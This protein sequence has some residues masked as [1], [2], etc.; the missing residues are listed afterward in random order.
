MGSEIETDR[1][2]LKQNCNG[3]SPLDNLSSVVNESIPSV[4]EVRKKSN[5]NTS[6]TTRL[7]AI[8]TTS[9]ESNTIKV[10]H[11]DTD[12]D[13]IV[14]THEPLT[15]LESSDVV[16][17]SSKTNSSKTAKGI[18]SMRPRLKRLDSEVLEKFQTV[19][20][21][22]ETLRK[23]SKSEPDT[24]NTTSEVSKNTVSLN[25]S[26]VG[27]TSD[28]EVHMNLLQ[29]KKKHQKGES[30]DS[31][32]V[33]TVSLDSDESMQEDTNSKPE[34]KDQ[35]EEENEGESEDNSSESTDEEVEEIMSPESDSDSDFDLK[36]EPNVRR[37]RRIKEDKKA[38]EKKKNKKN[39]KGSKSKERKSKRKR[40]VDNLNVSDEI[41]DED[42]NNDDDSVNPAKQKAS[43]KK[44]RRVV[45]DDDESNTEETTVELSSTTNTETAKEDVKDSKQVEKNK[46]KGEDD[47]DDEDGSPGKSKRKNIRQILSTKD[48]E[49]DTRK[50]NLEER[51]R[52]KRIG[53][54]SKDG[55]TDFYTREKD[56]R[57]VYTRICFEK[58]GED[59]L[60]C[61]H[62]DLANN[63]KPHQVEGVQFLWDCTVE[64]SS[65][66]KETKGSG[67]ILAHCMG[68]GKTLQ[69]ISFIHTMLT[70]EVLPF[71]TALIIVPANT[72]LNWVNEFE[73]WTPDEEELDVYEISQH[74]DDKTRAS[75]LKNWHDKGG[76]MIIGYNMFRIFVN[77][78]RK[79]AKR[80]L[81][82]VKEALL[83]P[84]PD[85]VVCDE[86]HLL[87]ND[88]T[89]LSKAVSQISTRR[90]I[91]LTGTPLQNNLVEYHCMVNFVKE[92]LLGTKN[93][94]RNRFINPISNGQQK[95]ASNLDVK[96]MK[97]RSHV[98]HELLAG[99]V[100]RR[101]YCYIT[102]YLPP[103]Y[104][105]VLSVR[106]S[107]RQIRLYNKYLK[108]F[109]FE[110]FDSSE[111]GS[112]TVDSLVI[113]TEHQV[114]RRDGSRSLF[115]DFQNLARI[116]THPYCLKLVPP[117]DTPDNSEE[118]EDFVC[119][120]SEEDDKKPSRKGDKSTADEMK[121]STS[122]GKTRGK[123]SD[124][125]EECSEKG[126][127][128][129]EDDDDEDENDKESSELVLVDFFS[130]K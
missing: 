75:V 103:K 57:V 89:A 82:K 25:D 97:R 11:T 38:K 94:F 19:E 54:K 107:E 110:H 55:M 53:E 8:S 29:V 77:P 64:S 62:E 119:E 111:D 60:V 65:R 68:L 44:K 92:N 37:S 120:D 63:L 126:D 83:D 58:K 76:I 34:S 102:K 32:L 6:R 122:R 28:D 15:V 121:P 104:E 61:M 71:T 100:Q 50:A 81:P 59:D 67:A 17:I 130:L 31:K 20:P 84:G 113:P 124:S 98:L 127:N 47:E 96:V 85:F 129:D 125:E 3:N 42:D 109:C 2:T 24:E 93:E 69:V 66:A 1:D 106:L 101:D 91:V 72:I 41:S 36:S 4:N 5:G 40:V 10:I 105:Y 13:E 22:K 108:L 23:T 128:D 90:R 78:T 87:K 45:F 74:K 123:R 56:G 46:K 51:E 27:T 43:K 116:W 88:Q 70:N 115:K 118:E 48:L 117:K 52:R 86:G 16:C 21:K 14:E 114:V 49:K 7:K 73:I 99:A 9:S 35:S 39:K 112:S 26:L 12:K 95:D 79:K 80:F 18:K 30:K 33:K